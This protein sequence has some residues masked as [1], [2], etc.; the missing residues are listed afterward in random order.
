MALACAFSY[1]ILTNNEMGVV[2]ILT[3]S[4]RN[5]KLREVHDLPKIAQQGSPG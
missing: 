3:L 2:S 1:L 4:R 5:L